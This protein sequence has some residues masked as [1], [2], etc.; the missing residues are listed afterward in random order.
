MMSQLGCVTLAPET[1]Q[2]VYS[3]EKRTPTEQA[4]YDAHPSVAYGLLSKIPG[5][6]PSHG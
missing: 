2:A 1:I 3:G 5:S 4:Q 6:N